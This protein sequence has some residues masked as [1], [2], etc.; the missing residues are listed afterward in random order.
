V[1]HP[2]GPALADLLRARAACGLGEPDVAAMFSAQ[3]ARPRQ[4]IDPPP[5]V[6]GSDVMAAGVPAGP[7]VGRALAR[8]RTLQLDG[9]IT[10]RDEA[11]AE[12]RAAAGG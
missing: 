12:A 9:E 3:V 1:A 8:I 7:A 2:Q 10:T 4:E 11:L 6:S 5:L